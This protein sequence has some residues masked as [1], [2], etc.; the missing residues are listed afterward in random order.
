MIQ[1]QEKTEGELQDKKKLNET[2]NKLVSQN[3]FLA[4]ISKHL[5]IQ[6]K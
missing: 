2:E 4:K 3:Y 1:S 6:K 5:Q